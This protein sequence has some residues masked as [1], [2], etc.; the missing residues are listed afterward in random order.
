MNAIREFNIGRYIEGQSPLHR[1]DPRAKLLVLPALMVA[2]FS[3]SAWWNLAGGAGLTLILLVLSGIPLWT[4]LKGLKFLR[5]LFLFTLLLHLFLTPGRTL[6][7]LSWVSYDGLLHGVFVAS[8]LAMAVLLSSLLTLTTPVARLARGLEAILAPFRVLGLASKEGG[9]LLVWVLH[10]VPILREEAL[11][12][13]EENR[14]SGGTEKGLLARA[15]RLRQTV[16]PLLAR[17]VGRADRLAHALAR[18]ESPLSEEESELEPMRFGGWLVIIAGLV[19][20][21]ALGWRY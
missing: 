4:H 2:V 1:L 5:Y 10:F 13:M 11:A 15:G 3:A 21:V 7:G 9:G 16:V 19:L 17:L 18:G 8:Q 20:A 6:F 14:S 12:V